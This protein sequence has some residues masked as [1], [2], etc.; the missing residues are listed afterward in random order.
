[1]PLPRLQIYLQPSVTGTNDTEG[2][3]FHT[4]DGWSGPLVPNGIEIS[5]FIFNTSSSQLQQQTNRRH[6]KQTGCLCLT[7]WPGTAHEEM[8]F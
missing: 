4:V 3:L 1:M 7:D 6:C 2:R 8:R 5:S